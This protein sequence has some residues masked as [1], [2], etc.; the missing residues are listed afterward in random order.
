MRRDQGSVFT[1][2]RWK[3][4]NHRNG[5]DLCLYIVKAHIS[6][7]IGEQL[8][9]PLRRIYRKV[10]HEYHHISLRFILKFA[11]KSL[12]ET[13]NERWLVPSG[14]A[15]G[16]INTN[17][18]NKKDIINAIKTAQAVMNSIFAE[19]CVL[20]AP[21][22][23]IQPTSERIYKYVAE[24][25]VY[26]KNTKEWLCPY[27]VVD[28]T[29]RMINMFNPETKLRQNFNAFQV[30]SCYRCKTKAYLPLVGNGTK[31]LQQISDTSPK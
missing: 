8:N 27:L 5:I 9:G 23:D 1:S 7:G 10:P 22:L 26:N 3:Q 14:L 28:G 18:L 4:P 21:I 6:L 25:L 24:V 11:A 19:R 29:G 17:L 30:R 20:T 13:S 16:N 15:F 31:V 2:I 12:N